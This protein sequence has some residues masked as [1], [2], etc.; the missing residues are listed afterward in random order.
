MLH[1]APLIA[2]ATVVAGL[3]SWF[4]VPAGTQNAPR[5]YT[6]TAQMTVD[7]GEERVTVGLPRIAFFITTGDIPQAAADKLK[8]ADGP[9]ALARRIVVAPD[10]AASTISISATDPHAT[11]AESIAQT[12]A[13]A[14]KAYF[15]KASPS[16]G[17]RLTIVQDAVAVPDANPGSI[18]PPGRPTRTALAALIGLL[19]GMALAVFVDRIDSRLRS[20]TEIQAALGLPIIAEVP[21]LPRAKRS[22]AYHMV[23]DQPLSPFADAYRAAR[24]ATT[25]SVETSRAAAPRGPREND[26][27]PQAV[28]VLV[29]SAQPSEGK[30]TSVA[31]LAAS[32]AESGRRV[33][34]L[35]ADLRSPD[36]HNLFDVP[37]GAGISDYLVDSA[38]EHLQ[39][40]VRPTNMPGVSI[41]VAGTQLDH[42]TSLASRMG[43][44]LEEAR[45]LADVVLVDT[46]PLLAASDVFD[47]LPLV[48]TVLVVVRSGRITHAAGSRLAELLGRFK[49]PV[50]GVLL[51]GSKASR[52]RSYGYGYGYGSPRSTSK[53]P[54]SGGHGPRS[55]HG[56]SAS[57]RDRLGRAE[58]PSTIRGGGEA[59][60]DA[61]GPR[62][63]VVEASPDDS[64]SDRSGG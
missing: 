5:S 61:A 54:R 25:H 37:Q 62:P 20:R 46:A 24:A 29:T 53:K 18:L 2:G 50:S 63:A 22:D 1:R 11:T 27:E 16:G 8:Y 28:A 44:L 33:L 7:G 41:I 10:P 43:P 47:I 59:R 19:F 12:F 48:D 13:E 60:H 34:V 30:T 9:F 21:K 14:A 4:L 38:L 17:T 15:A 39:Q 6:A 35:D 57:R 64:V 3:L 52:S 40:L 49:V 26:P 32:F 56:T 55:A 36:A 23:L 58:A 45:G 51:I 31:N 42:P